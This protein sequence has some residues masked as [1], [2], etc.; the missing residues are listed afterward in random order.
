MPVDGSVQ[1]TYSAR[2]Y[3]LVVPLA[4][5]RDRKYDQD[6]LTRDILAMVADDTKAGSDAA[7]VVWMADDY[8]PIRGHVTRRWQV[9]VT[10]RIS[11]G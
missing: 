2:R 5:L 10:R 8:P 11:R 1:T 9:E 7:R 6:Q 4:L 3:S